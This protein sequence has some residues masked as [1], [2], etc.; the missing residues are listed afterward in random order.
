MSV[1][2]EMMKKDDTGQVVNGSLRG[3]VAKAED[4]MHK[5][6]SRFGDVIKLSRQLEDL[7]K[8]LESQKEL[9]SK[10]IVAVSSKLVSTSASIEKKL[11][12]LRDASFEARDNSKLTREAVHKEIKEIEAMKTELY[13]RIERVEVIVNKKFKRQ[14][15]IWC[16]V[17][18][19]VFGLVSCLVYGCN[20]LRQV[21][22]QLQKMQVNVDSS[23]TEVKG[24]V[25]MSNQ[26]KVKQQKD[27]GVTKGKMSR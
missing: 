13:Q 1:N 6:S 18:V 19:L 2:L 20:E 7:V 22:E 9:I 24:I 8:G 15:Y 26:N 14:R 12:A 27:V 23:M 5:M 21:T 4:A 25:L 3:V 10:E 11:V 16:G 17:G